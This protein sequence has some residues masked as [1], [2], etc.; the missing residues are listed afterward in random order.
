MECRRRPDPPRGPCPVCPRLE[1]EED[2]RPWSAGRSFHAFTDQKLG[3]VGWFRG[4][5][6][7]GPMTA[8]PDANFKVFYNKKTNSVDGKKGPCKLDGLIA[9]DR[10]DL[11][12]AHP[13]RAGWWLL[14]RK[15]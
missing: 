15:M 5:V 9:N 11:G 13:C 12:A 2:L 8:V 7:A 3:A 1:T 6:T 4:T 14:L 10:R